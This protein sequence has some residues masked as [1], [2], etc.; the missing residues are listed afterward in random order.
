MTPVEDLLR[1]TLHDLA[2]EA[3]AAPFLL[4]LDAASDRTTRRRRVLVP[5]AAALAAVVAVGSVLV[6]RT[7]RASIVE[8]TVHPPKVFRLS[9]ATVDAPGRALIAVFTAQT[10][11]TVQSSGRVA[12]AHVQPAAGGP[13]VSL[14]T[15]DRVPGAINQ[16]LSRDGTRVV[17]ESSAGGSARVEIVNLATGAREDLGDLRG[18]C[19]QLSPDHRTLV[20]EE[21]IVD[22]LAFVDARTGEPLHGGRS[23]GAMDRDCVGQGWS[24]D[25]QLLAFGARDASVLMDDRGRTV[26]RIPGR[27]AV[28]SAMS[29]APDGRSIL[30]YDAAGRYVVRDVITGSESVLRRPTADALRPM[31]WAGSRVVWLAGQ[32]GAQRLVSTDRA[33]A[34]PRPWMRLDIG[35]RPVE[36]VQWS[37]AL[38]GRAR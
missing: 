24:P 35:D 15:S 9:G 27:V 12:T 25:G 33:G 10:V 14:S 4:R 1:S 20:A 29:W 17:R 13:A 21:T 2:D 22:R 19:P 3:Y 28:N 37:Q 23:V 30:L 8:P 5:V 7:D 32:P 16:Q 36:S 26:S 18:Y 34:E 38:T 31:G 11:D 6:L